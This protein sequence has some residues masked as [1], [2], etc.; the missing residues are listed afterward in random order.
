[1]R[2]TG[3]GNFYCV[4]CAFDCTP[5]EGESGVADEMCPAALRQID[6]A[7]EPNA[8]HEE[9]LL[10]TEHP[11]RILHTDDGKD[12]YVKWFPARQ[13]Y[14]CVEYSIAKEPLLLAGETFP[15]GS[16]V[17]DAIYWSVAQPAG[18]VVWTPNM[19]S[20]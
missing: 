10:T 7:Q 8:E 4:H 2:T 17:C 12:I 6:S 5:T 3:Q 19:A 20:A 16:Q 14:F 9:A 11:D 1:M 13:Q 18:D 15:V